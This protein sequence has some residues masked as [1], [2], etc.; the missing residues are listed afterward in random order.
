MP[1]LTFKNAIDLGFLYMSEFKFASW[2]KY[3]HNYVEVRVNVCAGMGSWQEPERH[4]LVFL[5][6]TG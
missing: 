6:N 5:Q 4:N 2:F 3:L 1:L